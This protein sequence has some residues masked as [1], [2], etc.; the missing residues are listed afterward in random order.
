MKLGEV[1]KSD[2]T[3]FG[4]DEEFDN[5]LTVDGLAA[6]IA[7]YK[8][9]E[10]LE[11]IYSLDGANTLS[12]K[13]LSHAHYHRTVAGVL[14]GVL[15]MLSKTTQEYDLEDFREKY[16]GTFTPDISLILKPEPS[17]D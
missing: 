8:I 1:G 2:R 12:P 17:K 7:A 13:T 9:H 5:S 14:E 16:C 10:R 11:H 4:E 3:Y 15:R 6:V